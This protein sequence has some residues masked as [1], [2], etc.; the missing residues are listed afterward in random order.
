MLK[1]NTKAVTAEE[2]RPDQAQQQIAIATDGWGTHIR[3]AIVSTIALV[4]ILCGAYPLIVWG[5]SQAIFP[6]N[7]NGS[8]VYSADGKTVIG[9]ELLSQAFA[10][11][12][13]FH[14]RPS[15]AGSGHDPSSSGGT[16]LGPTS[17]KLLN[18]IADDPATADTDESYA[19]IKHLSEA[20]RKTNG[21]AVDAI[22]PADAV[23]R[24]A[25]GVDPHISP[26]NAKLQAA[27]VGRS[28]GLSEAD[29]LLIVE[30][31]TDRASFGFLGEPGVNVFMLNL[32]LDRVK[33]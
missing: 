9:S 21:L 29:V 23:T 24:S 12:Q 19:G 4:A 14:P 11:E 10:G 13:Y 30:A 17:D 5:I 31:N 28:R 16:N 18:G 25:S 32:A 7:A 3:A 1:N 33:Q 2:T 26:A 22:V 27:R 6:H 15:A 8:L 20:Y